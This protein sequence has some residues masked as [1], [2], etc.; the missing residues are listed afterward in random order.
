MV[1]IKV[2]IASSSGSV[3][4]KKQQQAVVGFLEANGIQFQEVDIAMLE[5]QK[6]WMYQH[7]PKD[8]QPKNGK[9]LPPQIFNGDRYCG[10]YEDFF[11]SK[12]NN[13]VLTFLGLNSEASIKQKPCL[14]LV[15]AKRES[16]LKPLVRAQCSSATVRLAGPSSTRC[17]G[18]VEVLHAGEWGTVC[19]DFWDLNSAQVVCRELQCGTALAAYKGSR[20]GMSVGPIWLDDVQC[21][22]S[23]LS[24]LKCQHRPFGDNNCGHEEDAS[25]VCS[26]ET[27]TAWLLEH[28]RVTNGSSR[29]NG[30]LEVYTDGHWNKVCGEFGMPESKVVCRE[31]SCGNPLVSAQKQYFGESREVLA[32]KTTCLGN[33][34]SVA[35]CSHKPVKETCTDAT[36]SCYNS[37]PI[38]LVNGTNRCSGRVE[39]LHMDQWGTVCD[40]KWG[41][42]EASVACREMGCGAPLEVKY[43]AFF[44][45]GDD[46][47]WLDDL[48][49]TGQEKSLSECS[50]RGM[51]EHDCSHA[52]DAGVVCSGPPVLR[53]VNGTNRCSGRVEVY[54]DGIWGTVCDDSWDIRDAQ[55]VCRALDCGTAMTAKSGAYFGE[56]GG[57]IWLDDVGCLGNESSLLQ[58]PHSPFGDTNCNHVEDA[59]VMC[60]A[61]IRLINGTN[62]CSG[63]VEVH[64]EGHWSSV[65]NVQW[66]L[67]ETAVVCREM[68]CGDPVKASGSFGQRG[69]VN[70]YKINCNGRETSLTQC[71]FRDYVRS[72]HDRVQEASVECSGN[73]RL[74]GGQNRCTGRVE[75]FNNGRWGDVCGEMWDNDDATV[76]CRQLDCGKAIKITAGTEFGHGSGHVWIEQIECN[77]MESTLA[78][79]SQRSFQDRLCNIT[80]LAGVVCSDSL[81]V[82]LVKSEIECTGTVEVQYDGTWHSVC[83]ADW[84][85]AK[86]EVVCDRLECGRVVSVHGAA[87]YGQSSGPVVEANDAC[88]ANIS[89][90]EQC[91]LKGFTK[92]TCPH[93]QDAG[94]SCAGEAILSLCAIAKVFDQTKRIA[95]SSGFLLAAKLQLVGGW[96]GCSGRVEVFHAGVWGTICD[97]EWEVSA[98]DV[99]CRQLGCGHAVSAPGN[100]HF[101]RGTGPIWLDNVVCEGQEL[102]ITHCNHQPFGENNCGHSE[103]AGVICLERSHEAMS[104]RAESRGYVEPRGVTRLCRAKTSHEVRSSRA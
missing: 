17:S 100:A 52:E 22:G 94:V 102:A 28:L 48:D 65:F 69:D 80:S 82:R 9:P 8:K 73:V 88:F 16:P 91:S 76:V 92:S 7:I 77:G 89:H 53:L 83:D 87:H 47:T 99:V 60:S 6:F 86:A 27:V 36:I 104:S 71:S 14:H 30:R 103:D 20:F 42:Q 23:E 3:A 70:G 31:M 74:A 95:D 79:C 68:N 54:H 46:Q 101:G 26:G 78:Q 56:G 2:Y 97:D 51:G 40:D 90:L 43:K 45:S 96:S 57:Q 4:V 67:H 18:R 5:E 84:N 25:V 63:R 21:T 85:Q 98:A 59:S 39:I 32:V 12:E 35:H 58:C 81:E 64:H 24:I 93:D 10:D 62:Q 66:S 44:G 61:S 11:Q 19:D 1:N 37:Q 72:G 13:T 15:D 49:C 33:E 55:V 75:F 29:C 41:I 50:H 38:R 34:S